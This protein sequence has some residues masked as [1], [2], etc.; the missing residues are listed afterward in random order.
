[1]ISKDHP[2]FKDAEYRK[3]RNYIASV[4][5]KYAWPEI[6]P[7][8][9]YT[10]EEDRVWRSV[11]NR[12]EK[13][14]ETT[15][16]SGYLFAKNSAS[17]QTEKVPQLSEVNKALSLLSTFQLVPIAGLVPSRKFLVELNSNR[18]LSTQ[19]IRH[20]SVPDYTP[21]PDIIHEVLGHAIH[22]C[23]S[24][25]CQLNKAFGRAAKNA[26]DEQLVLIERLYWYTVEFGLIKE[27]GK[28]KAFGAGLLSSI[29]ELSQINSVKTERFDI[30]TITKAHYNT[31]DL[32]STLYCADSYGHMRDETLA[33]LENGRI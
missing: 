28:T 24:D 12:I 21:E 10:E 1:M 18:M 6:I 2:G 3:R 11:S 30:N 4:A 27:N 20:H 33:W 5:E 26:S 19:Y 15:A 8:V 9:H 32:Q 14:H 16:W 22:F 13:L 25:Y 31:Q 29:H 17:I 7:D 23:D